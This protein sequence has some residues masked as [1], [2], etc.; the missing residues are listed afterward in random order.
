M[1]VMHLSP[2]T[3]GCGK[4]A[5]GVTAVTDTAGLGRPGR[6]SLGKAGAARTE[7]GGTALTLQLCHQLTLQPLHKSALFLHITI[8]Y[9][10]IG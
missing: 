7:A 1:G 2:Y 9:P 5:A 6:G 10:Q 4:E 3:Q 8:S